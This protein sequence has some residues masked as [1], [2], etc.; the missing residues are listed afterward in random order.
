MNINSY[1]SYLLLEND[2]AK[3]DISKAVKKLEQIKDDLKNKL[4]KQGIQIQDGEIL[5]LKSKVEKAL[6]N[7]L[8]PKTAVETLKSS[9]HSFIA[10][11]VKQAQEKGSLS[12]TTLKFLKI[13][14]SSVTFFILISTILVFV[15]LKTLNF[16]GAYIVSASVTYILAP[17]YNAINY[18]SAYFYTNKYE[19][20][21]AGLGSY[22]IFLV[23]LINSLLLRSSYRHSILLNKIFL[24]GLINDIILKQALE[25]V[26][27]KKRSIES[28][29]KELPIELKVI[30]WVVFTLHMAIEVSVSF[31]ILGK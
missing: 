7:N 20:P 22:G 17:F 10:D 2:N 8:H 31:S 29:K 13:L 26:L 21:L 12:N 27:M 16:R 5:S 14:T 24:S 18:L 11:K 28:K 30:W 9:F 4:H 25:L 3:G 23:R 6:K 1:L 19:E 15:K